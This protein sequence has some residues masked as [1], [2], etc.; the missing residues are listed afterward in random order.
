MQ[1]AMT[2]L[3]LIEKIYQTG[4]ETHDWSAL[5]DGVAE[6]IGVRSGLV[7]ITN[8][9]TGHAEPSIHTYGLDSD[10]LYNHWIG[11]FGFE[12]PW[13]DAFPPLIQGQ[14]VTGAE[15]LSLNEFRRLPIYSDVFRPLEI[16]DTL[17][18]A[19][20]T[21]GPRVLIMAVYGDRAH[22]P[23]EQAHRDR[24]RPLVPHLV[25]AASL[26]TMILESGIRDRLSRAALDEIEFAIYSISALRA[27]P[28]NTRAEALLVSGDGLVSKSDRL[29]ATHFTS[30]ET[31]QECIEAAGGGRRLP[32]VAIATP[33]PLLR[34]EGRLPLTCW[35]IP[36]S[37]PVETG[38]ARLATISG[39][40]LFVGDP[41]RRP[42]LASETV[43]RLFGL[44]PAEARVASAIAS[45]ETPR[46]YAERRGL[47]ENT[48]RWTLKQVQSK[49][50]VRRQLDIA[51]VVLRAT[52]GRRE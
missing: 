34:G 45:G 23:F 38:L 2:V 19:L 11:D 12:N 42:P 40:L 33:F 20:S 27:V 39:A 35:T 3:R 13:T 47:R 37:T 43:A 44:T 26:E 5:I 8:F 9:S 52:P 14:I 51:S 50:G 46:E 15:A 25:R 7:G 6:H 24:L 16:D 29:R 32:P 18:A 10:A 41:E 49:L 48:V 28:L 36:T 21:E 30:N 31:L 4:A 17:V 22:G 1:E